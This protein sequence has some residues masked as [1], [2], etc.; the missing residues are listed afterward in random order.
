MPDKKVPGRWL[1]T[2][3]VDLGELYLHVNLALLNTRAVHSYYSALSNAIIRDINS[4]KAILYPFL[5]PNFKSM[6]VSI[7]PMMILTTLLLYMRLIAQHSLGVRHIYPV[8]RLAIHG[9]RC[10]LLLLLLI[11]A[12]LVPAS[13]MYLLYWIT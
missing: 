5:T 1:N 13:K 3:P 10:P 11:V 4:T 7:L 9:C 2:C 12:V 6:D 8:W